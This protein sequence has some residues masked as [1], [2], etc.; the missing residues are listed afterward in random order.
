M[1]LTQPGSSSRTAVIGAG[2]VGVNVALQ[3]LQEGHDVTLFD[4]L[5]PGEACSFGNSGAMPKHHA[6]PMSTPGILYNVPG[7]LLNPF[8]PLALKWTYLPKL[9]PWLVKFIRS[10]TPG[11]FDRNLRTLIGLAELSHGY[12]TELLAKT[13][14]N[15]Y[16]REN[17]AL[18]IYRTVAARDK[19]T[20]LWQRLR[21]LGENIRFVEGVEMR[22]IEPTVPDG[23]EF[24]VLGADYRHA[25]DPHALVVRL[26]E[27]FTSHGGNIRRANVADILDNYNQSVTV[28]TDREQEVFS[29]VVI[30]AGAWSNELLRRFGQSVPLESGRGY[31][32]TFP[33]FRAVPNHV[34]I[35]SDMRMALTPMSAGLRLGG[36]I[37]F[38]G[39]HSAPNFIR[40]EVQRANLNRLYPKD[41]LDN[42]TLWSGDRPMTPDSLPVIDRL[43]GHPNIICAFGHGQYGLTL[44]SITARLVADLVARRQPSVDISPLRFSGR[45]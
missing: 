36:G 45:F 17:S 33:D 12:W 28:R 1:A 32:M 23:Y 15:A 18:T 8:G 30:A 6:L 44:A 3:L 41:K 5:G 34:L 42:Y 9:A 2:V 19:A 24:G 14:A 16:V 40:A 37:E 25:L 21:E 31:Q 35:I 22:E 38:S 11:T 39:L 4:R 27:S 43:P 7:Y 10:G 20:W 13:G 26:A 29:N